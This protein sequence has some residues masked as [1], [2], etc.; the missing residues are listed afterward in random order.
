MTSEVFVSVLPREPRPPTDGPVRRGL[1]LVEAYGER[2][3][4]VA[5]VEIPPEVLANLSAVAQLAGHGLLAEIQR[6]LTCPRPVVWGGRTA[7]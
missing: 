6:R 3:T 4:G 1:I 5:V 7:R 2:D